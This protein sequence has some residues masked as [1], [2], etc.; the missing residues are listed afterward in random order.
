MESTKS[1]TL[2][3][4]GVA[5]P[6]TFRPPKITNVV[7]ATPAEN[8]TPEDGYIFIHDQKPMPT[9]RKVHFED[10]LDRMSKEELEKL[11][12]RA[13]QRREE[14]MALESAGSKQCKGCKKEKPTEEFLSLRRPNTV[15][16]TCQS[17]QRPLNDSATKD[18]D[19]P[20]FSAGKR[21]RKDSE[22]VRELKKLEFERS[23][24][25]ASRKA[26]Q[27]ENYARKSGAGE[28]MQML[29]SKYR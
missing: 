11:M 9:P 23:R 15:I 22:R 24:K 14:K 7:P 13:N 29:D 12:E 25:R 17:C 19:T 1:K 2:G 6:P 8:I 5:S 26:Q 20:A 3:S 10:I 27:E 18:P 21:E 16:Q 4:E 28:A